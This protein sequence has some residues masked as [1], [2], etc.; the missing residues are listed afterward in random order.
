MD[1]IPDDLRLAQ[2]FFRGV[3]PAPDGPKTHPQVFGGGQP[4]PRAI[5]RRQDSIPPQAK[6]NLASAP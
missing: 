3:D 1:G 5:D 4:R 6:D 2:A